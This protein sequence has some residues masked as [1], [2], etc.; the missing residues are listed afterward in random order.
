MEKVTKKTAST[1]KPATAKKT[2]APKASV[3][4]VKVE[5]VQVVAEPVKVEEPVKQS[6]AKKSITL[7]QEF[8]LVVGLLSI[9]TIIAFCFEF[10]AGSVS[11]SG[12]E[13]FVYGD[14]LISAAFQALIAI[15]VITLVVDCVMAICIESEN[16]IFDIVEKVLYMVT[17]II[18][19]ILV[20][21]LFCLISNVGLG[22][23]IFLILSILRAIIK[24]ARIYTSK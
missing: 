21:V 3:K 19:F 16:P 14:K 24:L 2:T 4:S 1:K 8:N 15:Y 18:N 7:N 13:M 23:I 11:I 9:L 6:A 5:K 12:W 22:L 20:V 17:L 10:S